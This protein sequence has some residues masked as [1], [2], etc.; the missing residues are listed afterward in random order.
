ML[1]VDP[2]NAKHTLKS[3]MVLKKLDSEFGI[4]YS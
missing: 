3:K 1:L 2:E 4:T